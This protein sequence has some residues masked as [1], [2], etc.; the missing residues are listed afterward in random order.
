MELDKL[1]ERLVKLE[2]ARNQAVAQIN[3]IIGS[4]EECRYWISQ[5]ENTDKGAPQKDKQDIPVSV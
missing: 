3:A 1:K 4:M 2:E 5:L